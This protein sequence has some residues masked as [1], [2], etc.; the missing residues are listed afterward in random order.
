[1]NSLVLASRISIPGDALYSTK[2]VS[3][4]VRLA[5]TRDPVEKTELHMQY[6]RERTTELVEL[7]ID[8][9]YD[10]IPSAALRLQNEIS[11]SLRSEAYLKSHKL[12]M[13]KEE[14]DQL[15]ETLSNEIYMLELLDTS[16][17]PSAHA[18]IQLAIQVAQTGLMALR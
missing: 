17:P 5:L 15:A 12:A 11:A 13:E 2:L 3:E 9:N 10:A 6:C 16:A 1:M 18:G 4:V 14:T 8:G 7:V